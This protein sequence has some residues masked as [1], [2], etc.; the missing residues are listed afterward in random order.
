MR[1]V[2]LNWLVDVHIKYK[3]SPET[4]FITVNIIDQYLSVRDVNRSE[5]QLLGITAMW[6]AAKY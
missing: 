6:I 1:V 3:M 5:L 4:F 2:L